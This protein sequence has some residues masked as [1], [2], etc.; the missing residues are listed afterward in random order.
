MFKKDIFKGPIEFKRPTPTKGA[1]NTLN[2]LKLVQRSIFKIENIHISSVLISLI[3][4][5]CIRGP[6]L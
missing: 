5:S 1:P 2:C 3:Y 4:F 6:R